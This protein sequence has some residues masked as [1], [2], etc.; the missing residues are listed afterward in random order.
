[1]DTI[2]HLGGAAALFSLKYAD[3]SLK[4]RIWWFLSTSFFT[5][6]LYNMVHGN[7]FGYVWFVA[8]ELQFC[9]LF[10]ILLFCKKWRYTLLLAW[11]AWFTFWHPVEAHARWMFP[12]QAIIVGI[13]TWKILEETP[14]IRERVASMSLATR[15]ALFW[16]P[17]PA[18]FSVPMSFGGDHATL[19]AAILFS[20][21]FTIAICSREILYSPLTRVI[22]SIGDD[23]YSL[24]LCHIP[25]IFTWNHLIEKYH[26]PM[27]KTEHFLFILI[28]IFIMGR[29]SRRYIEKL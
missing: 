25:L 12:F 28:W 13:F 2:V 6:N 4:E 1:M 16:L 26:L 21:S 9:L 17:I 22:K 29:L 27:T 8:C 23:S 5:G 20:V 3:F 10:A 24:Y 7:S 19:V 15:R 18:G 11:M 14:W